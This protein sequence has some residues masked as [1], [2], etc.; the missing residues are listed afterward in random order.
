[1]NTIAAIE[2]KKRGRGVE[3]I[4]DGDVW[5]TVHRDVVVECGVRRDD[6]ATPELLDRLAAAD[7]DHRTYES[8]LMLLSYRPRSAGEL[9]QRLHRKGL[10]EAAIDAA[11]AR[12]Q[13][14]GLVDDEQFARAW[15]ESR[16]SGS[17]GRGRQVLAGELRAKGVAADVV[18]EALS[19]VDERARALEAARPRAAR[20]GGLEYNDFRRKLGGFLQRRGFGYD[21]TSTVVRTLW[22]EHQGETPEGG[23]DLE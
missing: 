7:A 10:P 18:S 4:V 15:V 23:S 16:G 3:L 11:I 9:R 8:A 13:R 21:A 19:G 12:L 6:P 2:K 14:S 17:S 20:M 5:A 1:M 22:R